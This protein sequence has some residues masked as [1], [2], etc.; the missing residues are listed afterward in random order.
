LDAWYLVDGFGR[1]RTE[2]S[3]VSIRPGDLLIMHGGRAYTFH[4][5]SVVTFVHYWAHFDFLDSGKAAVPADEI[6][7]LPFHTPMGD[8][9]LMESLWDRLVASAEAGDGSAAVWLA[10]VL[11]EV[12]RKKAGSDIANKHDPRIVECY[13]AVDE[14]PGECWTVTSLAKRVGLSRSQFFRLFRET[15]GRSPQQYLVEA[16][17]RLA[18][19]LLRESTL[20]IASIAAS[21]G[22]NDPRFF[23]RHFRRHNGRSPRSFRDNPEATDREVQRA[24][25]LAARNGSPGMEGPLA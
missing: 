20:P 18:R 7:D 19:V 12:I 9:T 2:S 13:R 25:S 16:R 8:L 5:D 6:G 17:M 10:A 24:V 4:R 21:V 3:E 14:A 15:V 11:T 23:S 1:V 22:Y